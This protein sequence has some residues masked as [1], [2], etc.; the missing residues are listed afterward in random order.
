[1]TEILP[2]NRDKKISILAVTIV[3]TIEFLAALHLNCKDFFSLLLPWCP[4]R[5]QNF[6][7]ANFTLKILVLQIAS[8]CWISKVA[9]REQ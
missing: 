2:I 6:V 8:M 4:G 5:L 1:M 3:T 9:L 7:T